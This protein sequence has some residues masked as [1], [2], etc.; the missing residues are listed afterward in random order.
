M[1]GILSYAKEGVRIRFRRGSFP[2]PILTDA[3]IQ[4]KPLIDRY[5]VEIF[6]NDGQQVMTSLI[7]TPFDAAQISFA[8]SGKA[9]LE[10][11]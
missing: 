2:V 3:A 1:T 7:Y 5:S 4:M 9:Y 6:V 10:F 11:P 8:G